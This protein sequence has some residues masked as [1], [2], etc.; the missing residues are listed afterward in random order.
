[1]TILGILHEFRIFFIGIG[2]FYWTLKKT[3]KIPAA[4]V[5]VSNY[6]T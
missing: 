3:R 4:Y 6:T 1:M 5:V 2:S